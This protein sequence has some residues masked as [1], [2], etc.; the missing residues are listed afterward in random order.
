MNRTRDDKGVFQNEHG[1]AGTR[2]FSV[3]SKMRARCSNTK[4]HNWDRYGGRGIKVCDRWS[5]FANFF[6]D[7]GPAPDGMTLDRIDNNGNYE[8]GNCRWATKLTQARNRANNVV[9]EYAGRRM[10]LSE[11]AIETGIQLGTLWYRHKAG[12]DTPRILTQKVAR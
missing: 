12:W 3:W 7:M 2:S 8:P 5:E 4:A 1:M 6:A 9:L 11:W 10:C